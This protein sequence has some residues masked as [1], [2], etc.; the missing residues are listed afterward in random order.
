MMWD[1]FEALS[2]GYAMCIE[3]LTTLTS[4]K[5]A[6]DVQAANTKEAKPTYFRSSKL[7]TVNDIEYVV[8]TSYGKL[9]KLKQIYKMIS[10]CEAPDNLFVIEGEESVDKVNPKK[11]KE[12]SI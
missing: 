12:Y 9:D 6:T 4:V 2:L 7:F 1:V 11:K 8:G 10:I 5:R 3:K